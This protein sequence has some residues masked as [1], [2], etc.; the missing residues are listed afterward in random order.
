MGLETNL[1]EALIPDCQVLS[2]QLRKIIN[3]HTMASSDKTQITKFPNADEECQATCGVS[4]MGEYQTVQFEKVRWMW[5]AP[6][7]ERGNS[8]LIGKVRLFLN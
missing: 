6:Q 2:L 5:T 3:V 8:S 1:M 4:G 7:S